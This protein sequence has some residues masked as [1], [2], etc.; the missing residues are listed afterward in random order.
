M[1]GPGEGGPARALADPRD[2]RPATEYRA[3]PPSRSGP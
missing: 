2:A 3:T 1:T